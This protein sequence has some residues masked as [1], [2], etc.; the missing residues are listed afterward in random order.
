MSNRRNVYKGAVVPYSSQSSDGLIS[1]HNLS[2]YCLWLYPGNRGG[3]R[4]Q[5]FAKQYR[6]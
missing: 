5:G 2:D 3:G 1:C 4:I 6:I